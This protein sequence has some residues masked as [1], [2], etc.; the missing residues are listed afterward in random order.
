[1]NQQPRS[2]FASGRS[3]PPYDHA[4]SRLPEGY[5]AN[6]YFDDKGN[7][8]PEVIQTWPPALARTFTEATPKLNTAQLR[9]FYNKV[10]NINQRLDANQPFDELKEQ[11]YSLG[12]LVAAS[13]G[14]KTA[15]QVFKDFVDMNIPHAVRSE[16]HFRRGFLIHFQSVVA[17]AK[18]YNPEGGR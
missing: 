16:K 10:C 6:G 4:P 3:G 8:R 5:L 13:V 12:A 2:G 17:Y 14:R 1:M 18:Y 11:I 9:R 7:V 15:P